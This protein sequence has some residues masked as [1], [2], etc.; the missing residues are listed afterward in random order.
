[1][2]LLEQ[3]EQQKLRLET[4]CFQA[5]LEETRKQADHLEVRPAPVSHAMISDEER[6]RQMIRNYQ[7]QLLQQNRLHKQTVETARK[8][9]LEYQTVLK[10]RCP[11]MSARS[12]IPE[13]VVSEPPQQAQKPA[14]ASDYWDPS[15][16]PKL[17]PSKYQPV[18]PSQNPAQTFSHSINKGKEPLSLEFFLLN[19]LAKAWKGVR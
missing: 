16:R 11:S 14:V 5:Q 15:Q 17:S 2:E 19:I 4:D 9:L 3:I 12:L 8:R 13:S 10:E 1:M 18:Q 6:H 7:Y